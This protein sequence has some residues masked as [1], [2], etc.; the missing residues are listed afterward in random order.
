[1]S[2]KI[3]I[4]FACGPYDRMAALARGE[5][6]PAGIDLNYVTIDHP[7]DVFDRMIGGL[8]F[9]ASELSA[10]EYI[11]RYSAGFRDLVALPVFPSRVFRHG[12]IAVNENIIKKPEDLNG[13]K[14]GVQLYTMT[15]AVWIRGVLQ[16]AGVDLSS[17]TWVE[18]AVE[19]AGSHG[20][21]SAEPLLKP[22]K[23]VR[24]ETDKSLSQL[25]E[26]GEIAAT[27]GEP[28]IL[29]TDAQ[30]KEVCQRSTSFFSQAPTSLLA[31]IHLPT[32]SASTPTPKPPSKPTFA[33]L[34]S[35][36]SCTSSPSSDPFL[37]AIPS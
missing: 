18:G 33:K 24:N 6:K 21:P 16:Q 27:I 31:S 36:L 4:T 37:S 20:L 2:T 14:V 5:I 23:R 17:I 8:E 19:R 34:A 28:P 26:D 25:L 1:M 29:G 7:R 22:V 13:K 30:T 15:A 12:F 11:C 10:S 3:P 35:S 9:D 32:L